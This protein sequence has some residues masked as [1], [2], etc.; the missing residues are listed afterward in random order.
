MSARICQ[1]V[2]R[3]GWHEPAE[4]DDAE[5]TPAPRGSSRDDDCGAAMSSGGKPGL[6]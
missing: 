2:E 1:S 6:A 4:G 3:F 5:H